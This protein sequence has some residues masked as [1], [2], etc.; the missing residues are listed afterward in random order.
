MTSLDQSRSFI[1]A[2]STTRKK[3]VYKGATKNQLQQ[4][5]YFQGPQKIQ[6][7]ILPDKYINQLRKNY[8]DL[9]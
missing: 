2:F 7:K 8:Y 6:I 1:Q 3:E 9:V 5:I 4:S